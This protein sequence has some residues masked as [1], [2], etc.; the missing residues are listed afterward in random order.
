M[1]EQY[2]LLT[3]DERDD[4][5]IM[6]ARDHQRAHMKITLMVEQLTMARNALG[7]RPKIAQGQQ[8]TPEQ[9]KF[10]DQINAADEALIGPTKALD[11]QARI[12]ATL[13]PRLPDAERIQKSMDRLSGKAARLEREA[14]A[15]KARE[16]QA[17]EK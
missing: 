5:V 10:I 17:E 4:I 7:E 2:D 3:D 6:L 1:P 12:L 13:R 14:R 15:A 16:E 9:Q 8:P 11:E